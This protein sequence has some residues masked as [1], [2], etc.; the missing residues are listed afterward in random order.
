MLFIFAFVVR[1]SAQNLSFKFYIVMR[2]FKLTLRILFIMTI[3]ICAKMV[4]NE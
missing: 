3:A 1:Q 4:Y 2:T